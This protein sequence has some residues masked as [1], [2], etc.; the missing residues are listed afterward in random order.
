MTNECGCQAINHCQGGVD[1]GINIFWLI[2][3]I[4]VVIMAFQRY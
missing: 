1:N 3:I 4:L 2:L